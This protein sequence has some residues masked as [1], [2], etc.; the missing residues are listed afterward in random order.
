MRVGRPYHRPTRRLWEGAPRLGVLVD[1]QTSGRELVR[2]YGP[3]S[4]FLLVQVLLAVLLP[5][6]VRGSSKGTATIEARQGSAGPV[7]ASPA[8]GAA[9]A[10]AAGGAAPSGGPGA[11]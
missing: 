1:A 4:A 10:P 5:A 8:G 3:L 2:R 7:A 9:A 6:T 11:P